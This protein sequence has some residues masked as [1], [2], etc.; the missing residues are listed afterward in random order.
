MS[1]VLFPIFGVL[2][3]IMVFTGNQ[4]G[5]PDGFKKRMLALEFAKDQ[6]AVN[7]LSNGKELKASLRRD[8]E[9][10]STVAIPIYWIYFV[11]VGAF[12]Y[13]HKVSPE[14]FWLLLVPLVISIA[15]VADQIEN[16]SMLAAFDLKPGAEAIH[17]AASIKWAGIGLS[18]ALVAVGFV[19]RG[20]R[21]LPAAILYFGVAAVMAYGLYVCPSKVQI[22]FGMMGLSVAVTGEAVDAVRHRMGLPS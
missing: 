11:A 9:F 15:A 5:F 17:L 14:K 2:I 21:A 7:D 19:G 10:D 6:K 16:L 3:A 18:C 8:L 20:W 22:A 1:R 13:A 4:D 12:L